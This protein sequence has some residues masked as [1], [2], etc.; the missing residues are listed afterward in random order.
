MEGRVVEYYME[1]LSALD[2]DQL[3]SDLRIESDELLEA[4]SEKAL[5]FIE[6]E[7]GDANL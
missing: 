6:R 3:V 1:T 7:Y 5:L 4:F 2:P